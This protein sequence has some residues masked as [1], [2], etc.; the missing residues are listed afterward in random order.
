[1]SLLS[2]S[3]LSDPTLPGADLVAQGLEDLRQGRET[4]SGLLVLVAGPRLKRLGVAVPEVP[5]PRPFE[6]RLYARIEERLG[7]AAHSHYNSL[8]RRVVSYA[9]ALERERTQ[10]M[11][12]PEQR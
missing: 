7:N 10:E 8:L 4:E 1:M 11:S 5:F 3:R 2:S 12:A 6:H 9:R